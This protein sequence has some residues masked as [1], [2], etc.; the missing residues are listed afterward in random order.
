M[1]YVEGYF[2]IIHPVRDSLRICGLSSFRKNFRHH[3][4]K[5]LSLSH[6]FFPLCLEFPLYVG[7][8][9]YLILSSMSL[10]LCDRHYHLVNPTVIPNLSLPCRLPAKEDKKCYMLTFSNS[11]AAGVAM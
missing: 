5:Y 6:S 11:L 8:R 3:F 7:F 4:F 10:K 2:S 1:M 9:H